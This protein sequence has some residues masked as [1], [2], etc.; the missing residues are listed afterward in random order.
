V[1]RTCKELHVGAG[2]QLRFVVLD[3]FTVHSMR[4]PLVHHRL[5]PRAIRVR[6]RAMTG[7]PSNDAR[8][9][10]VH[11]GPRRELERKY[12]RVEVSEVSVGSPGGRRESFEWKER[13][14]SGQVQ[15]RMWDLLPGPY[16]EDSA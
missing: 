10:R 8:M 12:D 4:D 13:R 7:Y 9:F 15:V 11:H 3:A 14:R 5:L 1:P 6:S 2:V 16:G